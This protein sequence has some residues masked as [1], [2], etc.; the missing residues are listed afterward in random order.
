M[1]LKIIFSS[2]IFLI[3]CQQY[4]NFTTFFNT[5]YNM[6]RLLKESEEEFLYQE[7]KKKIYPRVIIPDTKIQEPK[8]IETSLPPFLEEFI[9]SQQQRQPVNVKLDSIIIKGSK[10]LAKHPKSNYIQNTLYLMAK[11]YFYQGLWLNCQVKCGELIDRFPDGELSPDAHLLLAKSLLIQRKFNSGSLI[12]SRTVDIAWQL[13]RYDILSEAFRIEA[14]LALFQKKYDEALKPYKQAI[15]QTDNNYYRAKWQFDLAALV[16]RINQFEKAEKLFAKVREYSPDYITEFESYIYQASCLSRIGKFE[17]AEE[18]LQKLEKDGKFEEWKPYIF[19]ERMNFY[20]L[21]GNDE[22]FKKAQDIADTTYVG[23]PAIAAVYYEKAYEYFKK[24]A[25]SDARIYFARAKNTNNPSANKAIHY[26]KLLETWNRK[27]ASIL[28]IF[29]KIEKNENLSVEEK[30]KFSED[31]FEMARTQDNL[32][33]LDS[34]EFYY[35][36]STKYAVE[37]DPISAR[38]FYAKARF[39]EISKPLIYDSLMEYIIEKYPNTEYG[40]DALK[41]MGYTENFLID[42]TAE[43]YLSGF[44]LWYNKEYSFAIEQLTKLFNYYPKSHLAPKAIFTIAWIYENDLGL[45]EKAFEYYKYLVEHYEN[46]EYARK[47]ERTVLYTNIMKKNELLPDS[48]KD[49]PLTQYRSK[50][51]QILYNAQN[52]YNQNKEKE[53]NKEKTIK[54]SIE[55]EDI[56]SDP[57]K[58]F[59]D[60]KEQTTEGVED[61]LNKPKE[62]LENITTPDS[63]K[64]LIPGVK[65]NDPF[66]DLKKSNKNNEENSNDKKQ[67]LE[68]KIEENKETKE[69]KK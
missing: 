31:L 12:L 36:M 61:L 62:T 57:F 49:V 18:I 67:N 44:R 51:D 69:K 20:R 43:L 23:N 9:I 13:K 8:K 24:K 64:S 15:L 32:G 30:K 16:F 25:Y 53:Q 65:I 6:N 1:K 42:S 3:S 21:Q 58:I 59:D 11:S 39:Y 29:A 45:K 27:R 55:L 17:Q 50:V 68:Q 14:E 7:Q 26:Y 48:L 38:Y 35:D 2:I 60:I 22:D 46:S 5:Y 33:N 37:N 19:A 41:R 10:I 54:E 28:P 56:L 4:D 47:A 40:Q 66:K 52:E 63:L 34:A